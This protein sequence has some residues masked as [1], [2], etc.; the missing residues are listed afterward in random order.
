[1]KSGID[2]LQASSEGTKAF[3][4]R[5]TIKIFKENI[6][7]KI[8]KVRKCSKWLGLMQLPKVFPSL[9]KYCNFNYNAFLI[10]KK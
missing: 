6:D 1:M 2:M 8:K 5:G 10:K 7:S 9:Y 4:K 3:L